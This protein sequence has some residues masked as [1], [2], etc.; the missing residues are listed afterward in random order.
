MTRYLFDDMWS[1]GEEIARARR[2]LLCLEFDG[3]VAPE[4]EEDSL[5]SVLPQMQRVLWSLA[6]DPRHTLAFLS[7]RSRTELQMRI[8]LPDAWYAGCHGLEISGPGSISIHPAA[9]HYSEQ[10]PPLAAQLKEQL[11]TYPDL[12]CEDRGLTFRIP[13]HNQPASIAEQVHALAQDLASHLAPLCRLE[14]REDFLEVR[15]AVSWNRASAVKLIQ[16]HLAQPDA[17]LVYLGKDDEGTFL[18]LDDAI[19]IRVGEWERSA[20]QFYISGP[21]DVRR[22]LEWVNGLSREAQGLVAATF[23]AD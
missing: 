6:N 13:L 21:P 18:S 14:S 7:H 9:A 8:G 19:T 1:V 22:F 10:L 23:G 12:S 11:R 20:A 15:P 4:M 17:L 2:I 3:V 16:Q 5:V